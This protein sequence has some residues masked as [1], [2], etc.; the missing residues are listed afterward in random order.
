[1]PE[2]SFSDLNDQSLD[3]NLVQVH[4][5]VGKGKMTGEIESGHAFIYYLYN[6]ISEVLI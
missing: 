3:K 5:T 1:M 2:M 4:T 6:S